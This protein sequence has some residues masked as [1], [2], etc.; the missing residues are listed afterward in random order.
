MSIDQRSSSPDTTTAPASPAWQKFVALPLIVL[1]IAAGV[2]FICYSA[3]SLLLLFAGIL[4]AVLL[5]AFTA[6]LGRVLP[7]SRAWRFTIVIVVL[8]GLVVLAIAGSA[9]RAPGQLQM[10][11]DVM[12][13][14]LNVLEKTLAGFG[15]DLFG[16]EGRQDLGQFFSDPGRLFGHV[17]VAVSGAYVVVMNT[18]VVV[19]LGMFFGAQPAAYRDGA[20]LLLPV[21]V[22][23]RVRE[24]MNEMGLMLRNWLLGQLV[25]SAVVAVALTV[26]FQWL[27]LP[28]APL[29]ALQAGIANFIPYLGPL[30]AAFPVILVAMPLG[31]P[32]VAWVI[33]IYFSIQTLEGFVIAPLIQKGSVNLA[34]AWTLFA[35]VVF[36]ALFGAMGVALAAPL[37]AI[38]RIAT[39]R[40]YVED[41]LEGRARR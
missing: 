7:L 29:L 15:I 2:A 31:L 24:V 22:R 17:H 28:G 18:I 25:R 40:F 14:Q 26:A 13:S 3:S 10:L 19:C 6:G 30:L 39:L 37:L 16:P 1:A 36:G 5:D 32:V 35:I 27:G 23:P 9:V 38:A 33:V 41:W 12:D 11:I 20:V 4:F 8:A 21:A 34:P